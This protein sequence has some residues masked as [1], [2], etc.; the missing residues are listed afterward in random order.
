MWSTSTDAQ[1]WLLHAEEVGRG[2]WTSTGGFALPIA[3]GDR[4]FAADYTSVGC[5]GEGNT[6]LFWVVVPST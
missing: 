6:A 4:L 3:L 2:I 5:V 1:M